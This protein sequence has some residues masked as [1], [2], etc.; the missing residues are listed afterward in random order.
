[1][2]FQVLL[3]VGFL[4]GIGFGFSAHRSGLCFSNGFGAVFAGK[5]K[6]ICRLFIVIFVITSIGFLLSGYLSPELG[7]KPVGV[8][9]GFGFYNLVAGILFGAGMFLCGGC[10]IGTLRRIGEGNL[11]FLVV[12]LSF[13]PGMALVVYVLN[14]L[15]QSEYSSVKVLLP[16]LLCMPAP[17]VTGVLV[18]VAVSWFVMIRQ[19]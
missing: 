10:V 3:L 1:M 12:L 2:S 13:I 4:F 8:V 15:L 16:Q 7:L 14:P 18:V 9:R 17:Y 5:G 11:M 6:G 19:R